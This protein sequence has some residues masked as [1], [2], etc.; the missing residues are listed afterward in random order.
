MESFAL[1]KA[2]GM[3]ERKSFRKVLTVRMDGTYTSGV[4][5]EHRQ[6]SCILYYI[7]SDS[8]I[9]RSLLKKG[10]VCRTCSKVMTAKISTV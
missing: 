3:C 4:S 2:D 10:I 6:I 9:K 8:R 7:S 1:V 5:F